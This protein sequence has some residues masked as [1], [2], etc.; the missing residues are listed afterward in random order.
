MVLFSEGSSVKESP[1]DKQTSAPCVRGSATISQR[2]TLVLYTGGNMLL[3]TNITNFVFRFP[4][5]ATLFFSDFE[6]DRC[7]FFYINARNVRLVLFKKNSIVNVVIPP[8]R[9]TRASLL[10]SDSKS[11]LAR[12]SFC[13]CTAIFVGHYELHIFGNIGPHCDMAPSHLL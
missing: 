12:W 6:T 5:E 9:N 8:Q 13:R 1:E 7:Q 3:I 11:N 4:L 10:S 2:V